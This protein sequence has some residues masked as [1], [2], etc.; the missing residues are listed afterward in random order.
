MRGVTRSEKT[1]AYFELSLQLIE[2]IARMSHFLASFPII[3][4]VHLSKLART[5]SDATALILK[6]F[7][8]LT[9][10]SFSVGILV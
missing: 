9:F 7:L 6:T 4:K 8:K 2:K 1:R 3:T 5:I 10:K